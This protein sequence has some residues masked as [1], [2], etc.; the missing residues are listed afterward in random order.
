[1]SQGEVVLYQ[2]AVSHY[3]EKIR[4]ALDYKEIDYQCEN[5]L[6]GFHRRKVRSIA[7]YTNVPILQHNGR[8]IQNSSDIISYLDINF[9]HRLLTPINAEDQQAAL[10]WEYELDKDLGPHVRRYCYQLLL[11]NPRALISLLS[12]QGPWYGKM[13]LS[14]VYPKV[15]EALRQS[16]RMD[17]HSEKASLMIINRY[18]DRLS[19]VYER[20]PYLVGHQFS[21]ADLTA[22]AL[23][24]PLFTPAHYG[25]KW[26]QALPYRLQE[27]M[28]MLRPKLLWAI[29]LYEKHRRRE[30]AKENQRETAVLS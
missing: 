9:S 2:F 16:L 13:L 5:L 23:F 7:K 22:A 1:M 17:Q 21:R 8:T 3:C 11:E 15:R 10:I 14:A 19:Q 28:A 29:R 4:W 6:P 27:T 24:A 12:Q 18:L 30:R 25:V 26:P 20:S